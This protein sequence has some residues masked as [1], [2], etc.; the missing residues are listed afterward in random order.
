MLRAIKSDSLQSTEGAKTESAVT[1][2]LEVMRA[3]AEFPAPA[4]PANSYSSK[5]QCSLTILYPNGTRIA[6]NPRAQD[7]RPA[8]HGGE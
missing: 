1:A 5:P 3:A 4:T 7:R 6:R 8:W 2:D